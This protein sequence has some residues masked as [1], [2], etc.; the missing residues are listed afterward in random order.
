MHTRDGQGV[1]TTGC[2]RKGS[3]A[4]KTSGEVPTQ[5]AEA[6]GGG[7]EAGGYHGVIKGNN[8]GG[9]GGARE[10]GMPP[11]SFRIQ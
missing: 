9:D 10:R 4:A 6:W 11:P 1:V 7:W 2:M 8:A 5:H 3:G